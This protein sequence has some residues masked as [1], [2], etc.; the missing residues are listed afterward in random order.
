MEIVAVECGGIPVTEKATPLEMLGPVRV[1]VYL[2]M[3]PGGMMTDEGEI[4]MEKSE[5]LALRERGTGCPNDSW[6]SA[7]TMMN[8][9]RFLLP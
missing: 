8:A 2:A 7:I 6:A 4:E 1:I 9:R 5:L 3:P